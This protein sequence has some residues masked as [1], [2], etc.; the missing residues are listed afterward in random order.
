MHSLPFF[1]HAF[2][3][4]CCWS[5]AVDEEVALAEV[6]LSPFS[7]LQLV[8]SGSLTFHTNARLR[9]RTLWAHTLQLYLCCSC[10]NDFSP[11]SCFFS[12]FPFPFS[13]T[14]CLL[15]YIERLLLRE[16]ERERKRELSIIN[17]FEVCSNTANFIA[18]LRALQK[19]LDLMLSCWG[20]FGDTV[21]KSGER[22]GFWLN[23]NSNTTSLTSA[24]SV[25]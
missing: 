7:S 8:L 18:E 6:A 3:S 2:L 22:N 20:F 10:E 11:L 17:V 16:R 12:S 24:Q 23:A 13:T 4:V 15:R 5:I 19:L 21:V 9:L 14:L 1:L 25:K